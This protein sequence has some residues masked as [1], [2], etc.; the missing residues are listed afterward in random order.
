MIFSGCDGKSCIMVQWGVLACGTCVLIWGP[1]FEG[2]QMGESSDGR[3]LS[4]TL[5][6]LSL[7][8][9]GDGE[10]VEIFKQESDMISFALR[11]IKHQEETQ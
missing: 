4:A 5:G 7:Y 3:D 6:N 2:W 1:R 9:V 10:S 11:K 8:P